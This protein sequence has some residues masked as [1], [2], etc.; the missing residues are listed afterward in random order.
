[1]YGRI[2]TGLSLA[3]T[4][5]TADVRG[6]AVVWKMMTTSPMDPQVRGLVIDMLDA[7]DAMAKG[8]P[9]VGHDFG[10]GQE[11]FD[12]QYWDVQEWFDT[13]DCDVQEWFY[14]TNKESELH[15]FRRYW[16]KRW[17]SES[18]PRSIGSP[19]APTRSIGTPS[20]QS[21]KKLGSAI[22]AP[23]GKYGEVEIPG[24]APCRVPLDTQGGVV[25]MLMGVK[26]GCCPL[27]ET[28]PPSWPHISTYGFESPGTAR[29]PRE[30]LRS[31]GHLF[32]TDKVK[33]TVDYLSACE[34]LT[35]VGG[36]PCLTCIRGYLPV[37]WPQGPDGPERLPDGPT[38]KAILNLGELTP[39]PPPPCPPW[40]PPPPPPCPPW[41]AN[42]P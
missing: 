27:P 29:Q 28:W 16:E 32:V 15:R 42:A 40:C 36:T 38:S 18:P 24:C 10:T 5:A 3:L 33:A 19:N 25:A 2:L 35:L 34:K 4:V 22:P 30:P 11:W 41:C 8:L 7:A 13:Q 1:M 39:P 23:S 12:T 37:P 31:P 21:G 26:P 14:A 20:K 6:E 17:S 9:G